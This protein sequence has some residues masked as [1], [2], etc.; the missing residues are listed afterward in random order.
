MFAQCL[1]VN[2]QYIFP[3]FCWLQKMK[4]RLRA[5]AF[6]KK[7][8]ILNETVSFI[9]MYARSVPHFFFPL[10]SYFC[11]SIYSKTLILAVHKFSSLLFSWI[12]SHQTFALI[13][14]TITCHQVTISVIFPFLVSASIQ[15]S[16]SHQRLK[17]IWKSRNQMR[18]SQ[19]QQR[20]LFAIFIQWIYE[21]AV[22]KPLFILHSSVS[23]LFWGRKG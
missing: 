18:T 23:N 9:R 22:S 17:V 7:L 6:P 19:L 13:T 3:V 1:T 16:H 8:F 4:E 15:G 12:Q 2:S 5:V 14:S 10:L 11:A 21:S 20:K